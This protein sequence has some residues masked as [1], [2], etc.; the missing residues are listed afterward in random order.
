MLK[1][2]YN[3]LLSW[4]VNR[5]LLFCFCSMMDIYVMEHLYVDILILKIIRH[6]VIY[7]YIYIKYL[8]NYEKYIIVFI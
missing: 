3:I 5:L 1:F 2:F 4:S 8:K 7:I 6:Y